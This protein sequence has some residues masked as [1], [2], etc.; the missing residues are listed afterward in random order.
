MINQAKYTQKGVTLMGL[1]KIILPVI[2]PFLLIIS[3][4][5]SPQSS[6]PST[7]TSIPLEFASLGSLANTSATPQSFDVD[8]NSSQFDLANGMILNVPTGAFF[9]PNRLIYSQVDI[10]FD[11]ISFTAKRSTFYVISPQDEIDT[12]RTALL[13]QLPFPEGE[14]TLVYYD[15]QAWQ[16]IKGIPGQ[17]VQAEI[18][19][20]SNFIWGY[21]EWRSEQDLKENLASNELLNIT[22]AR[23][24][25]YIENGDELTHA[26]FGVGES[27]VE[28]QEQMCTDL[29]AVLRMYNSPI[30]REF[31]SASGTFNLDLAGFL[32]DGS[33]PEASGGYYYELT[34][35]SLDDINAKVLAST[36]PLSPADVLKIAIEANGGNIPMGV[37]AAHNYLKN[38]KY[39]GLADFH[40][41]K[42]FPSEQGMAASHLASWREDSNITPAGEYDKM[43]PIYHIFAAMTAGVWFPTRFGGDIAVNGEAM[44]RTFQFL[45][46]HPD[47]QKA[48]ADGCGEDAS[49]WLRDNPPSEQAQAPAEPS[50]PVSSD[51]SG[52]WN[53]SAC[54]EAEGTYIYRWA[55]SLVNDP[56]SGGVVGTVKFH[57]CPGGGRALY[58]VTGDLPTDSVYT[59]N[60]EKRDGGGALFDASPD[61]QTFIFDS[62]TQTI[63]PNFAP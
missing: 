41:G 51:G 46:D 1:K 5:T 52:N 49:L 45:S 13:L 57:D 27:A 39:I 19:H 23:S 63:E 40:Y 60:G 6:S 30:N 8:K 35:K 37:L 18:T 3:A 4:C 36:T 11:Q 33:S 38:I 48:S 59:L 56:N 15:G 20:F 9:N 21:L 12:L 25:R 24:R 61:T 14:V 42:P 22:M 16:V 62:S 26:F 53:G 17:T 44:L 7:S 47:L 29:I 54:A 32:F 58:R 50:I 2:M 10:A 34:Q 55:V 43:G 28:S 31:P